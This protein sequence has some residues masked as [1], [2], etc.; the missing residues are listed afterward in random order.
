MARY[1]EGKIYTTEKCIG[2]NKCISSC[3][4]LGANVSVLENGLN[5]VK[6]SQ[7]CIE[8]GLC[9]GACAH[10]ARRFS[11]DSERFLTDLTN[12]KEIALL[13]D[14]AFYVIYGKDA[15][16]ILTILKQRGVTSI[17]DVA[18]GADISAYLQAKYIKENSGNDH[19]CNEFILNNCSA[20][21]M[22]CENH[23]PGLLSHIIPVQ[24][25]A[26][27]TAIYVRK[28][29]K[30][31]TPLALL[32]PCVSMTSQITSFNS[33]RHILY[34]VTFAGL[35]EKMH[36]SY[37][38]SGE[39]R[40][41]LYSDGLGN[42]A[43]YRDGF[44]KA[45]S[46]FF[47]PDELF[48][49]FNSV[50]QDTIN[51]LE[52]M[53]KQGGY[54]HPKA[55]SVSACADSCLIGT[56]IAT[57][58]FNI[59]NAMNTY[60][61]LRTESYRHLLEC[62]NFEK[63]YA[64]YSEKFAEIRVIDFRRDFDNK[65]KQPF[66]V[67]DDAIDNIFATMHKNTRAKQSIN[68][69]S[70]GYATCREMV[71]AVA[72]GYARMQDCVHYMNDD[73]KFMA[74]YDRMTGLLKHRAFNNCVE[75]MVRHN[76][77]KK[78]FVA[79]GDINKLKNVNDLYGVSVGDRLICYIA[80]RLSELV[81]GRGIA[82]RVSG[83]MFEICMDYDEQEVQDL[84]KYEQV[85]CKHLGIEFPVTIRY[86]VYVIDNPTEKIDKITNLAF[87][88]A[89]TIRDRAKN[90]FAMFTD[91]MRKEMADESEITLKMHD[92]MENG[93]FVLFFQPQY[94]HK[95]GKITG[96]EALTRWITEDG[97]IISPGMFIP[98]FEKSGF[99]KNMDRYVW[100]SAFK[101]VEHW[102][103]E[104]TP[105]VPISVNIS[106]VSLEEDAIV[107]ILSEL[108]EKYPI[109]KDHL[110]FEITESAYMKQQQQLTERIQRIKD[111]GFRIAMD[112]FGSGYS[113]LNSLK[114]I[115]ID[116]LKLD[117]G[118]LRGGK[119]VGRGNE[120]I[121]HVI[122]MAKDLGYTIVAE[123][124]EEKQ[125]ADFLTE[126][127]CDIIQGYYY[128]KPMPIRDYEEKLKVDI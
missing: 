25:P 93:E 71:E 90:S 88:A 62:E 81:A 115:P 104:K 108:S 85:Q 37:R 73:L 126:K 111:L 114:D 121:A 82:G 7:K 24:S 69:G 54:L 127:G 103:K 122:S 55:V 89:E 45:V 67:P 66:M 120:I 26:E 128:A 1:N 49:H 76:P 16:K 80:K 40:A 79:V 113:S 12:G 95:T 18:Y 65:Y 123:G 72:N 35:H 63:Y 77:D 74:N 58:K 68:C 116:V 36:E 3:P 43:C 10:N 102:E 44:L 101:L 50:N 94:N 51:H 61:S 20:L 112:D 9:V 86:G 105:I 84:L 4:V 96:A 52:N 92:A 17:Y 107:D 110:Y 97:R 60:R 8:C 87:Y 64:Y 42:L 119:N 34:N 6:V 70:C 22:L 53:C 57:S 56:G 99:I 27:C 30:D 59:E 48:V 39:T 23:Y 38:S 29:L 41:D 118:F 125:Q 5:R 31:M 32:S 83:G 21:T 78:Y 100:E 75:D 46:A 106:R 109:D 117:M 14:P 13:V 28:Y 98:V 2:C 11:D 47:L 33:G 19:A 124:V 15:F 91:E